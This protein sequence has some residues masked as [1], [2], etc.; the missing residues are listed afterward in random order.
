MEMGSGWQLSGLAGLGAGLLQFCYFVITSI[1]C[2]RTD[3]AD[4]AGQI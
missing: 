3:R 4:P 1:A 2:T